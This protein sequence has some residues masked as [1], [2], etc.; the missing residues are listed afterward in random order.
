MWA[1]SGDA[2][3]AYVF[4][5]IAPMAFTQLGSVAIPS[6]PMYGVSA[7][8]PTPCICWRGMQ[9]LVAVTPPQ[10]MPWAPAF[11]AACRNGE[12]LSVVCQ[13]K[14]WW[15]TTWPPSF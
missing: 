4:G 6:P 13:S 2:T 7:A 15:A 14:F 9:L 12:K 10:Y 3:D 1:G 8:K 5:D 11:L